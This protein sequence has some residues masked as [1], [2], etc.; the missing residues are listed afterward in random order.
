MKPQLFILL[1]NLSLF[2]SGCMCIPEAV[3]GPPRMICIGPP[4]CHPAMPRLRP[5]GTP[6]YQS[7]VAPGNSR[8]LRQPRVRKFH[9][10]CFRGH[11]AEWPERQPQPAAPVFRNV[12]Q[13]R[14]RYFEYAHTQQQ[15]RQKCWL[16][17]VG[18]C[19]GL[20][21]QCTGDCACR[22]CTGD[23]GCGES[24]SLSC[25]QCGSSGGCGT[26]AALPLGLPHH[27]PTTSSCNCQSQSARIH[28]V[29]AAVDVSPDHEPQSVETRST[30]EV[31]PAPVPPP[32]PPAQPRVPNP[33][34]DDATANDAAEET[35]TDLRTAEPNRSALPPAESEP[36]RPS[37]DEPNAT[38]FSAP[39]EPPLYENNNPIRDPSGDGLDA[40]IRDPFQIESP[41]RPAPVPEIQQS[42]LWI[43]YPDDRNIQRVNVSPKIETTI[44]PG[45]SL[46]HI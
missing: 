31:V 13:P 2:S 33:K 26:S 18:S 16:S 40:P 39:G 23:V 37:V 29:P 30:S 42:S 25:G 17:R 6:I 3:F 41:R 1:A 32:D 10:P 36:P 45:L 12:R 34:D 22:G 7:M 21:G 11:A 44:I 43:P 20:C 27:Q 5:P 38:P 24:C 35:R 8:Q 46:I 19:L 14:Q 28:P 9:P 15:P 4:I